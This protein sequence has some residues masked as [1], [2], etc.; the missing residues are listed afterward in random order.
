MF[1][2]LKSVLTGEQVTESYSVLA[3]RFNTTEAAVKMTV[4]RL[5]RRFAELLRLEVAHTVA[6]ETE[7]DDEVRYLLRVLADSSER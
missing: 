5:R 1:D 6:N 3:T 7:I 2:A 4:V